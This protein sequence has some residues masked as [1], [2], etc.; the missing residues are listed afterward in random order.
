[1]YRRLCS[2]SLLNVRDNI[3]FGLKRDKR[4]Q[5]AASQPLL[6]LSELLGI[7]HLLDRNPFTL[8]GGK[9]NG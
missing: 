3:L 2:L 7:T 9:N 6:M 8:S 4:R 5:G 1:M